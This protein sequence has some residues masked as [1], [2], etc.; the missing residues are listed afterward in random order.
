MQTIDIGYRPR[1]QF[2]GF[3]KR[4][5]RWASIVA[6]RRAGK[7]VACVADLV[8]A[9]LRCER[10]EPRFAYLA[11]YFTQAKD[12]AWTYLKRFTS[13]IPGATAHEG[14]LRVDLP[15]DRRIRLYGADNADRMRGIYLD[16]AVMDEYGD[17]DPNVW[18]EII[19][20][21]LA[22][23]KGWATFIGTPKGRNAFWHLYD[24]ARRD[25]EWYT[26]MLKASETGLVSDAE[27][28]DA[29]RDMSPDQYAQ[30]FECSFQAAIK[31]A[32]YGQAMEE[33]EREG[34]ICRVPHE[35][36]L[37]THTAWDLGIGDATAIWFV[38]AVGGE[39]RL[40]DY[41]EASG[42]GLDHYAKVLQG[43]P[44][45]YGDHIVPHDIAVSELGTGRT[46]QSILAGLGIRSRI[47][48]KV[49][50]DDGIG[51]ARMMIPRCWFDAEKCG[52]GIE[53][54]RQYRAEYD[55]KLDALRL[56]PRHDW[57][58]HA[59]DAF[60][61]LALGLQER[62]RVRESDEA[63]VPRDAVTGY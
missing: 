22:D 41:Y 15:G 23:R 55:P 56:R 52:R 59:A 48:P 30:E 61:Y 5:E 34:R 18:P 1:E 13:T 4:R 60:R 20:P 54:L 28:R 7:T 10:Q 9:A 3:H 43:K 26:V 29:R 12:I 51:A 33:A 58:S 44:Y 47:A 25:P 45:V 42:V 62:R 39:I 2:I 40:I 17:I 37:T 63:Y 14:E 53:A 16:G 27:L 19:R 46:R 36:K 57:T 6:H 50:V 11:P 31:G 32:Y 49:S 8:D 35:P 38:Q 24:K 21:A